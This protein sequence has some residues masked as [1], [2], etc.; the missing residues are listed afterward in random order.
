MQLQMNLFHHPLSKFLHLM[1]NKVVLNFAEGIAVGYLHK[2][3]H[4]LKV[5]ITL[6]SS[7]RQKL[8]LL[9][10]SALPATKESDF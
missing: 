8:K 2:K 9:E 1:K 10:V 7:Y 5:V 6:I 4:Q 3:L